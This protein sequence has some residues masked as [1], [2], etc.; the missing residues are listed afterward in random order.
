MPGRGC[1]V[2]VEPRDEGPIHGLTIALAGVAAFGVE[3][4]LPL[5]SPPGATGLS[6]AAGLI[7]AA[8]ACVMDVGIRATG[9]L[10]LVALTQVIRSV[11]Y[12][13]FSWW[14][15]RRAPS[16]RQFDPPSILTQVR[17]LNQLASVKYTVQ[18]VVGIREQRQC[19]CPPDAGCTARYYDDLAGHELCLS[20][21]TFH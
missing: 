6:A 1:S 5:P 19:G 11:G 14:L 18:K 16:A 15:V 7:L 13:G 12:L 21:R 8:S 17:Q 10:G 9:R 3:L 20:S 2:S 4:A